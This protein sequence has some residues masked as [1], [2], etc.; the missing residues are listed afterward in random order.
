[1]DFEH[2]NNS[3]FSSH[4]ERSGFLRMLPVSCPYVNH[5]WRHQTSLRA[6]RRI[7][8]VRTRHQSMHSHD[9][10]KFYPRNDVTVPPLSTSSQTVQ[11]SCEMRVKILKLKKNYVNKKCYINPQHNTADQLSVHTSSSCLL[12]LDLTL[13]PPSAQRVTSHAHWPASWWDSKS[14]NPLGSCAPSWSTFL[15]KSPRSPPHFTQTRCLEKAS[16]ATH[17]AV[18][19]ARLIIIPREI[20][21]EGLGLL[22]HI[23]TTG[24][25]TW[26]LDYSTGA[27]EMAGAMIF[28]P[29]SKTFFSAPSRF[30]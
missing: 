2:R 17:Q 13:S 29:Y 23:T 12:H 20:P 8:P 1:M 25:N 26:I 9:W 6:W 18:I 19:H 10:R 11:S 3:L 30:M 16:W 15:T 4:P 28:S 22:T 24:V 14:V 21:H 27:R 5:A 7:N